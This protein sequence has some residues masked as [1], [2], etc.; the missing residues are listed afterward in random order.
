M[1]WSHSKSSSHL[2]SP[3]V[4]TIWLTVFP[5]LSFTTPWLFC[6]YPFA[7]VNPFTFFTQPP[8]PLP[9]WKPW[10]CTL[11]LCA[12]FWSACSFLRLLFRLHVQVKSRGICLSMS[13]VFHWTQY[14]LRLSWWC[15]LT[16]QPLPKFRIFHWPRASPLSPF[17]IPMF[18][19]D[20]P[21]FW[22]A[23][24][25]L[26]ILSIFHGWKDFFLQAKWMCWC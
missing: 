22:L 3:T 23:K 8:H 5:G 7:L 26:L 17:I 24:Y 6:N 10:K 12:C 4:I 14:S 1:K 25:I 21:K 2:I 20:D 19:S 18:L 11:Y 16:V 13:N 15:H 9:I